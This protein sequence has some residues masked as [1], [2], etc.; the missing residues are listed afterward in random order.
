MHVAHYVGG[1]KEKPNGAVEAKSICPGQAV[2]P[3]VVLHSSE[4]M[5][6]LSMPKGGV[7][8]SSPTNNN[9]YYTEI[10]NHIWF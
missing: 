6:F 2:Y 4:R 3:G 5:A 1:K 8:T 9:D 7:W 10:Q